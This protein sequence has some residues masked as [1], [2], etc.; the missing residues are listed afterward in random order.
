M[1][2]QLQLFPVN[3][4]PQP[5]FRVAEVSNRCL[6]DELSSGVKLLAL[7]WKEPFASLMLHGK[8]ETRTW[9][10]KYRGLVLICASKVSYSAGSILEISGSDYT[11]IENICGYK[12]EMCTPGY[13]IAIG[14]LVDCRP[15]QPKD[16]A[17]CFVKYY[18]DL[19]CHIYEDV[20][21]I[22]PIAWKGKQGWTNVSQDLIRSIVLK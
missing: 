8:I 15:M 4:A 11:R 9:P 12:W 6:R 2:T 19:F 22:T 3:E 21:P 1:N 7:S 10:T 13:A 18:K 14:R 16:E 17:K 5:A 20:Q